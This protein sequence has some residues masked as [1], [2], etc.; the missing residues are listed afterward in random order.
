MDAAVLHYYKKFRGNLDRPAEAAYQSARS[1]V[2]FRQRLAKMVKPKR[3]R[4]KAK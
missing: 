4:R 2:H 3:K 1:F